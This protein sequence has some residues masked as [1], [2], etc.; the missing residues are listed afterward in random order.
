MTQLVT[1]L[2]LV[3]L[4]ALGLLA[5]FIGEV[6][7]EEVP[8]DF[9]IPITPKQAR[10]LVLAREQCR[11][12]AHCYLRFWWANIKNMS[13]TENLMLLFIK[14]GKVGYDLVVCASQCPALPDEV[15][16]AA[17]VQPAVRVIVSD[18]VRKKLPALLTGS[19]LRKELDEVKQRLK[20]GADERK[21]Q[22]AVHES[23]LEGAA[24]EKAAA[25]ELLRRRS[26]RPDPRPGN[27]DP[28]PFY[29]PPQPR[30]KGTNQRPTP[31]QTAPAPAKGTDMAPRS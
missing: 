19:E 9:E 6:G 15:L 13:T 28:P 26:G 20:E 31:P 10:A 17:R 27:S 24:R 3:C 1:G 23:R 4:V 21:R 8:V 14:E 30:T 7:G 22:D 12:E 11:D 18:E 16:K 5:L 25:D 29:A 2:R